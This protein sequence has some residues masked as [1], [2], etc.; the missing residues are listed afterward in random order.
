MGLDSSNRWQGRAVRI[1][2]PGSFYFLVG[3]VGKQ[4]GGWMSSWKQLHE[5]AKGK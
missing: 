4:S 5:M 1:S 2:E 3:A